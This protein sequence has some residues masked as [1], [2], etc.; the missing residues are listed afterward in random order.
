MMNSKEQNEFV[1]KASKAKGEELAN[2]F[3]EN[4]HKIRRNE[5]PVA[6]ELRDKGFMKIVSLAPEVI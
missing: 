2:I 1:A 5:R 4:L 6:R 3:A